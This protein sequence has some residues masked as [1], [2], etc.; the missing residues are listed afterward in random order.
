MAIY[1]RGE[2]GAMQPALFLPVERLLN[3][4]ESR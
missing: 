1:L 3:G 2:L 4:T